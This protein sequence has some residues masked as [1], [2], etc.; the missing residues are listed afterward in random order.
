MYALRVESQEGLK[1]GLFEIKFS[2]SLGAISR[3]SRRV[4]TVTATA[5]TGLPYGFLVESQEGLK[6][7]VATGSDTLYCDTHR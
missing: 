5:H 3:I 7:S 1:L 6:P 4:E 2:G